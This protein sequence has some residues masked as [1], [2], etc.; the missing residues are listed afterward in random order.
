MNVES[1]TTEDKL[2]HLRARIAY[3]EMIVFDRED[4][5]TEWKL[6][7]DQSVI[8]NLIYAREWVP[9]AKLVAAVYMFKDEPRRP[10]ETIRCQVSNMRNKLKPF[11]VEIIGIGWRGYHMP[12]A[13]KAIVKEALGR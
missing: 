10:S 1:K 6:T 2:E 9:T 11:G 5:P 4:L 13:S 8:F 3:L 7:Q 12:P